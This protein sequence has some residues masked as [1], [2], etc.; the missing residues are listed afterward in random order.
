M[1]KR[2][3]SYYESLMMKAVDGQISP[4]EQEELDAFLLE[5]PEYQ[6][7]LEDFQMIK[8]HTDSLRQRILADA[9]IEPPRP[10]A[11]TQGF[12]LFN[13]LLIFVGA[14]LLG[15]LALYQLFTD[16]T[17][18]PLLKFGAGLIGTGLLALF[19]RILFNR[20]RGLHH[21]PYREIDQ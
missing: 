2:D 6:E 20:M 16:P 13:F 9:R 14:A 8:S 1:T 17:V 19:A 3:Q 7:E 10:T 11:A 18:P 5:H 12:Q 21:D 15:G 4:L